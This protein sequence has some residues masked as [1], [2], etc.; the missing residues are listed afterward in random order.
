MTLDISV[1]NNISPLHAKTTKL[2]SQ[3]SQRAMLNAILEILQTLDN[4][5]NNYN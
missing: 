5:Q 1:L 2:L 3:V 4:C